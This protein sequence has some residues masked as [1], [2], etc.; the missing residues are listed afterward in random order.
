MPSPFAKPVKVWG[1]FLKLRMSMMKSELLTGLLVDVGM[2]TWDAQDFI[3]KH[4]HIL[5]TSH[6]MSKYHPTPPDAMKYV[7]SN[8]LRSFANMMKPRIVV[9]DQEVDIVT[10]SSLLMLKEFCKDEGET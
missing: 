4:F 6:S 10:V 1:K 9:R 3:R 8:N 5:N 2:T 7:E